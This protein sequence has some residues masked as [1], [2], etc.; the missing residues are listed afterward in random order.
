MVNPL[1]K[2][3]PIGTR[4]VL[5][6]AHAF[7]L[8]PFFVALAW[9]GLYGFPW[10]PRLWFAFFLHDIGYLSRRDMDGPEGET[11]PEV[12]ATIMH[13]LFDRPALVWKTGGEAWAL[14]TWYRFCLYH[15][16]FYCKRDGSQPSRL[17]AADKL[18]YTLTPWWIFIPMARLSGELNGYIE[19]S[20]ARAAA[21]EP[22]F[23]PERQ[24][25]DPAIQWYF[26]IQEYSKRWAYA[27][28]DG[29]PDTW[30]PRMNANV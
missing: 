8:H 16:R 23:E 5:F 22:V 27:H 9:W 3:F 21:G 12:G 6:G 25:D 20:A 4:S 1:K 26:R 11:H 7:W 29:R 13:F 24:S 15:S 19:L 14:Q 18:A 30:T 28:K 2:L 10:D 17:C